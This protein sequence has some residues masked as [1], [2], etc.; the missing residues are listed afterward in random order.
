VAPTVGANVVWVHA[1][2]V[3]GETQRE[4]D[5]GVVDRVGIEQQTG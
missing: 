5:D 4:V 1:W 2:N 3:R